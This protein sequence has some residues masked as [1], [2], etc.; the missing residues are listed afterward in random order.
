MRLF[1]IDNILFDIWDYQMSYLEF[2][3][4]IAG[5][6]FVVLEAKANIWSWPVAIINAFLL[7]F[8][9]YQVQLYPD[10]F[11]QVFFFI[12]GIIGWWR[13]AHPKPGEEDRKKELKVSVMERGQLF[14]IAGMGITGTILLGTFAENLHELFP[15]VFNRP[16]AFPYLD[17]F[18]TVMS[19][20]TTFLMIQKKIESWVIW[21][22]VDAIAS[23]MYFAK[24]IRFVSLQYLIFCFIAVYGF[25]NWIQEYRNYAESQRR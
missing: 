21:I 23:Y 25:W 15:L 1:D 16:S 24:G 8:L 4:T 17:S 7:F 14:L 6:V 3:A 9:F 22:V 5:F 10:M 12:T 20:V 11:L 2:I 18:V 19:V 13:W